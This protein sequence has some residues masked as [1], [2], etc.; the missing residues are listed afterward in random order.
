MKKLSLCLWLVVF[1]FSASAKP[2]WRVPMQGGHLFQVNTTFG[3]S[4]VAGSDEW[5]TDAHNG[6]YA[7]DIS[8]EINSSGT[9]INDH[10]LV[11]ASDAGVVIAKGLDAN[12]LGNYVKINHGEGYVSEYGHFDQPAS[13][14][15]GDRVYP[16]QLLGVMGNTGNVY[17][18]GGGIHLDWKILYNGQCLSSVPESSPLPLTDGKYSLPG[19]VSVGK[20]LTSDNYHLGIAQEY[21]FDNKSPC[22][23]TLGWDVSSP[24]TSGQA[25][26]GADN[27]SW[28]VKV[29]GPNPGI[30]SPQFVKTLM[31]RSTVMEFSAKVNVNSDPSQTGRIWVKDQTGSWNNS[32]Q[33]KLFNYAYNYNNGNFKNGDYNIYYVD[34]YNIRSPENEAQYGGELQIKQ[35]SMELTKAL[36]NTNEYWA[37]DWVKIYTKNGD[38][39]VCIA[40]TG[41]STVSGSYTPGGTLSGGSSG[42]SSP[43]PPT[44]PPT[45]RYQY[46]GAWTCQGFS[47]GTVQWSMVP[48]NPK[49]QFNQGED[50]NCLV[51]IKNISVN[52]CLKVDIYKDSALYWTWGGTY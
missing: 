52:H 13:V 6:Y 5:H 41:G 9:V 25:G 50:V 28:F 31:A 16:G 17:P 4:S 47:S 45:P 39:Y 32:V 30:V 20:V 22:G 26:Y 33:P 43:T 1:C 23:W 38:E 44:P 15:I 27:G 48:V 10:P 3:G 12:G 18:P 34:F 11:V 49:T 37:I 51:E 24:A 40:T 36:N 35:F 46:S 7:M 42:G 29:N 8:R 14:N 21:N 2:N 19:D